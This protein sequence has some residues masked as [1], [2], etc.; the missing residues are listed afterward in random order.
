MKRIL[1]LLF[2][3]FLLLDSQ[4]SCM[5]KPTEENKYKHILANVQAIWGDDVNAALLDAAKKDD[6]ETI[7]ALLTVKNINVH[8][9][10]KVIS[11]TALHYAAKNG[12]IGAMQALIDANASTMA[13]DYWGDTPL[14][15]AARF[16]KVDAINLLC[17]T[18]P[19]DINVTNEW[20]TPPILHR[21][22]TPLHT[23]A[24]L[25]HVGAV[26]ALLAAGAN[27]NAK[28]KNGQ[29]PLD[30]AK[31]AQ[32]DSSNPA[33]WNAVIAALE[34]PPSE[35]KEP[36]KDTID[37]LLQ[38]LTT[39][40]SK[41]TE[42]KIKL[43]TL[44][45]KQD[46]DTKSSDGFSEIET[47]ISIDLGKLSSSGV[48]SI[49]PTYEAYKAKTSFSIIVKSARKLKGITGYPQ[50]FVKLLGTILKLQNE[51][52]PLE[53]LLAD[54]KEKEELDHLGRDFDLLEENINNIKMKIKFLQEIN[55]EINKK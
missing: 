36:K 39:L 48:T 49:Y 53:K 42:L 34:N 2:F 43:D 45:A 35:I 50:F 4:I 14:H 22:E 27:V 47:L 28:N 26:K 9:K 5:D 3:T 46:E 17:K 41:L 20:G 24:L 54:E 44:S 7:K 6:V 52:K 21:G 16:D 33:Q 29:T 32:Q 23:A 11:G 38:S 31:K 40:H 1:R 30:S 12:N 55:A 10:D 15:W 8:A 18:A 13:P 51:L 19:A 37:K 25:G